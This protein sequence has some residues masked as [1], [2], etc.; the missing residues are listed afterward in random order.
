MRF[1]HINLVVSDPEKSADFYQKHFVPTGTSIWLGNSLH[2]RDPSGIDLA[3]QQGTPA[4]AP[5]S[6]QGFLAP[7][8]SKIDTL[9]NSLKSDQV[10]ITDDCTE[11]GF[12]SIKC[13]DPDGYEIE[14]YWEQDWP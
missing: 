14:V 8:A 1:N 2:L 12:R 6:H 4:Q 10:R 9:L 11:E 7:S 13:L 3:F 5:G